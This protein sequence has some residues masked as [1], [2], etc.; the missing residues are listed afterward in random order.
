MTK[1]AGFWMRLAATLL[2]FALF[3]PLYLAAVYAI[4]RL[5]GPAGAQ[6]W[7]LNPVRISATLP[8][9]APMTTARDAVKM[10]VSLPVGDH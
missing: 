9:S 4:T 3:F 8:T 5:Y 6:M 1:P 7:D 2:D 10:V